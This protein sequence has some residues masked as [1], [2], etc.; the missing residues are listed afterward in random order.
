MLSAPTQQTPADSLLSL[1]YSYL[2]YSLS[3]EVFIPKISKENRSDIKI[4]N[5]GSIE[6]VQSIESIEN[7]ESIESIENIESTDSVG[8]VTIL[9]L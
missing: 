9:Q 7:I 5:I 8:S 1:H 3:K 6:S 2:I 4:P